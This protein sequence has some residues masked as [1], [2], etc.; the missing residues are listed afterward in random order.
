ML[1]PTAAALTHL[2]PTPL[3]EFLFGSAYYPEH[4]D[5]ATRDADPALLRAAGWNVVRMGE[6]AWDLIEPEEGK[7]DFCLFDETI[8]RMAAAG[9]RTIFCTPTAAP[10]RWLTLRHPE[11]LRVDADG[12]PM[13]HG[14]RQHASYFSPVFREHSR[15]I[16][17]ALAGHFAA[18]PHV[19]GWQTD[20]EFHC[21]FALDHS[22]DVQAAFA[23]WLRARFKN[24]IALLNA[25]WGTGFWSQTYARFEDVPTP[26]D[27]RPTWVNPAHAL[28]YRRFLADG[29]AAFQRDQVGILRAAN[30]EWWITHNGCHEVSDYRGDLGR[31]L[32]FVSYDS[33]PFF[34]LEPASRAS[35]H[36][37]ELDLVRSYA[38]NF[39][40]ME[41][42]SGPGGQGDYFLDN[43]EPGEMR[44]LAWTGIARGADGLL[45]FRER[46]CRFGA[47]EYWIGVL[48]HDN[49]PRRRYREAAQI[50]AEAARVGRELLGTTVRFDVGVA[51]G[52]F[53]CDQ[54]HAPLSLGL[55][56]PR[57]MAK[58]LHGVFFRAGCAVGIVHPEDTLQGLELY[59]L[60]HLALFNPAW[61][62]ALENFVAAGG[63]LVVGARTGSKDLDN[64]VV[65]ATLPGALRGLVGATVEEYGRQNRPAARPLAMRLAGAE[66]D[67][68]TSLWYEQ[69]S[70]DKDTA[71]VGTWTT[72]HLAGKP[73]IT[74]RAHGRGQVIYVGTYLTR[75]FTEALLPLLPIPAPGVRSSSVETVLRADATRRFRILINHGENVARITLPVAGREL[76]D[77]KPVSGTLALEPNGVAVIRED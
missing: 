59:V 43:P 53:S 7:F 35:S 31:D 38:G 72:R 14:S 54:G 1:M 45:L 68:P 11:A 15:R 75:E 27:H 5:A 25:A 71:V 9:I 10:P 56:D 55:P 32:D 21:H 13:Q 70:P 34:D 77:E 64:N 19:I 12:R 51:A 28:D 42:Q 6:F 73:A 16:T 40:V 57:A 33:Y 47:E 46:S 74:R 52:D 18:N 69:L 36:A 58:C 24:D 62:P 76:L 66:S 37:F 63:T 39:V 60:P 3:R 61:L 48:D 20:N 50:G 29:I 26:R 4:W 67:T 2:R 49:V 22:P 44:R 41:H 65:P 23:E 30:S 8:A 17:R